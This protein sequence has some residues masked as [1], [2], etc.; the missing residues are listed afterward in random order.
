MKAVDTERLW[1][2]RGYAVCATGYD[3]AR[4]S[5]GLIAAKQSSSHP[6]P[7]HSKHQE[8]I[9]AIT[10]HKVVVIREHEPCAVG[11]LYHHVLFDAMIVALTVTIDNSEPG[12]GAHC[13]ACVLEQ[14]N[15]LRDFVIGLEQQNS[16]HTFFRQQRIIFTA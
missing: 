13:F 6:L 11:F 8:V 5:A 14:S 9:Y 15:W 12:P 4:P 1:I 7:L 3:V 16:V 10:L 2:Q